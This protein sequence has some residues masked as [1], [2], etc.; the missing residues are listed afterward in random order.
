M[1][2]IIIRYLAVKIEAISGL[3]KSDLIKVLTIRSDHVLNN[4]SDWSLDV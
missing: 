3:A 1:Q 4:V 2:I